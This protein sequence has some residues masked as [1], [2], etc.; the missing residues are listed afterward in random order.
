MTAR[1]KHD[2]AYGCF[3]VPAAFCL[4]AAIADAVPMKD[5]NAAF[6]GFFV[7]IPLALAGVV[8]ILIGVIFSIVFWRDGVLPILSVLT[9]ILVIVAA[10]VSKG[11]VKMDVYG[12]IYA[13]LV[14]VLEGSWFLARRHRQILKSEG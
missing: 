8:A 1:R 5:T 3:L 13:I 14:L 12:L 10:V 6:I 2:I 7:L 4:I 11:G 9:L